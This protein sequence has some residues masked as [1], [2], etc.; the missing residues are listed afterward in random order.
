MSPPTSRTRTVVLAL[1]RRAGDWALETALTLASQMQAHLSG[2]FVEDIDLLRLASLPFAREIMAF[3]AQSR[4]LAVE[5]LE[6]TLRTQAELLQRQLA[7]AAEARRIEWSFSVVRDR[8]LRAAHSAAVDADL[9]ILQGSLPAT[10]QRTGTETI[11]V[12]YKGSLAPIET[13]ALLVQGRALRVLL[14]HGMEKA[15]A[16]ISE[17]LRAY[18]VHP[19]FI[20]LADLRLPT[21]A[22]TAHRQHLSLLILPASLTV[23]NEAALNTLLES[24]PCSVVVKEHTDDQ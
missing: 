14:E 11:G 22:T 10:R 12:V 5:A 13:A 6:E 9:Y 17:V 7:R 18:H 4:P 16:D 20:E 2:L 3:N 23:E 15:R 21:I 1:D 19:V 24:T 8:L